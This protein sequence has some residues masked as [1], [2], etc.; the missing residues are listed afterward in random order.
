M[1]ETSQ[2]PPSPYGSAPST[3]ASSTAEPSSQ[4]S[5]DKA[6]RDKGRTSWTLGIAALVLAML[7]CGS[8]VTLLL[9]LPLG[10]LAA[11]QARAVLADPALDA[12]TEV[13]ARTGQITGII[14]ALWS[15]I[16]LMLLVSLVVLYAG[17]FGLAIVAGNL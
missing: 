16:I 17:I 4:G 13:Y 7:A 9:A 5:F 1:D 12:T 10:M 6:L 14:A 11:S 8:Y 3:L 15:G 2:P